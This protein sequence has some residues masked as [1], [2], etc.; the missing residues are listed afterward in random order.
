MTGWLCLFSGIAFN[1]FIQ[2]HLKATARNAPIRSSIRIIIRN[3]YGLILRIIVTCL[4]WTIVVHNP[5]SLEDI[6]IN[7][8]FW[9]LKFSI[10]AGCVL[11][12]TLA[13]FFDR[14]TDAAIEKWPSLKRFL[15]AIE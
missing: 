14:G 2:A 5:Q 13:V 15:P 7:F 3:A 6:P 11:A 8:G 4:L 9:I 12:L 1:M 10:P